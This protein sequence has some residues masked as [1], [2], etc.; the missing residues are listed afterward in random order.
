MLVLNLLARE[1][2]CAEAAGS[3]SDI[4]QLLD[5][6]EPRNHT[7]YYE[8]SLAFSRLVKF[9]C[10]CKHCVRLYLDMCSHLQ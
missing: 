8:I 1:G 6:F 10:L 3:L 5:L 9:N 4:V 7:L 2:K